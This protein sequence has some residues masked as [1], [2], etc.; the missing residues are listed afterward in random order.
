MIVIIIYDDI[1]IV[2]FLGTITVVNLKI[3]HC[4]I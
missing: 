1:V 4:D 3:G 2:N